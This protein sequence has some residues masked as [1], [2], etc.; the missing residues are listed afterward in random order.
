MKDGD[1]LAMFL[2]VAVIVTAYFAFWLF[3]IR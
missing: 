3:A 2:I 1:G